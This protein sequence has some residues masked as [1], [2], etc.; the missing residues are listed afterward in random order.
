MVMG[1]C[2]LHP[3]L[4]AVVSGADCAHSLLTEDVSLDE[5]AGCQLLKPGPVPS[6]LYF[7]SF[8]QNPSFISLGDCDCN[9]LVIRYNNYSSDN[10]Q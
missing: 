6:P 3:E 7:A 2:M 4:M 10:R 8:Y 9:I 5:V 1:G